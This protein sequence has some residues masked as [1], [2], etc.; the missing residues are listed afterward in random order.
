MCSVLEG[1]VFGNGRVNSRPLMEE[2]RRM[3][4]EVIAYYKLRGRKKRRTD[5][6]KK[7]KPGA[8]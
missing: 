6:I 4:S 5:F 8:G 1:R 3:I 2:D 7:R